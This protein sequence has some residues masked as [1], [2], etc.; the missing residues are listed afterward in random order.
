M[1]RT[2]GAVRAGHEVGYD[3]IEKARSAD[4]RP[5]GVLRSWRRVGIQDRH[6]AATGGGYKL[7]HHVKAH[8]LARLGV[9]L[10]GDGKRHD[11]A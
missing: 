10:I 3:P 1:G 8:D 4:W 9:L 2:K 5:T 11:L 6:Q 7:I